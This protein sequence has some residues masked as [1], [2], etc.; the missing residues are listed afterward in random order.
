MVYT[1]V[2]HFSK[3][4]VQILSGKVYLMALFFQIV[5]DLD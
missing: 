3:S 2:T 5:D 1:P 4:N